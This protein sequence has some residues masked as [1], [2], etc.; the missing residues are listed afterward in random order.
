MKKLNFNIHINAPTEKVWKTLWDDNT[1]RQW[2]SV[3]HEGSYAESDWKEGSKILFLSPEGSGMY[4]RIEKLIENGYMSFKHLG[5]VK[6]GVEQ[7]ENEESKTWAGAMENYTLKGNNN[8]TLLSVDIDMMD[9][10][11]EFFSKAFPEALKKVK[12]LSEAK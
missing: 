8:A 10:H 9:A 3:F 11:E 12:E 7:P 5:E 4:S 2:T 6:N 1:Y